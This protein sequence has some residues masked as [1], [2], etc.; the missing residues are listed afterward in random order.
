VWEFGEVYVRGGGVEANEKVAQKLKTLS[1]LGPLRGVCTIDQDVYAVGKGRQIYKRS[2][3]KWSAI[4][5]GLRSSTKNPEIGGFEAIDKD[6]YH[7]LTIFRNEKVP[8]ARYSITSNLICS[9][10]ILITGLYIFFTFQF[11]NSANTYLKNPQSYSYQ[12]QTG[13]KVVTYSPRTLKGLLLKSGN[14][15]LFCG[16]LK[17]GI[18]FQIFNL[19]NML[20][21]Y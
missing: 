18:C 19:E 13:S 3:G 7:C 14:L 15:F 4:D 6:R 11:E 1:D 17:S 2:G 5:A 16:V 10:T 12:P 21:M 9:N 8:T 20:T